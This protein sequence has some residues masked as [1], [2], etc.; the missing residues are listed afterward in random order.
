MALKKA[1]RLKKK[2]EFEEVREKG[3]VW[4]GPKISLAVLEKDEGGMR[5]GVVVSKKVDKRA[6][7][8]NRLRRL[9][10]EVFRKN[11]K[12]WGKQNR[13]LVVIVRRNQL[14]LKEMEEEIAGLLRPPKAFGVLPSEPDAA[15]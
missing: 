6:V 5:V 9:V 3:R 1:Y 2:K 15:Q 7:E 13:W 14:N 4:H 10:A 12:V 8:R 11:W